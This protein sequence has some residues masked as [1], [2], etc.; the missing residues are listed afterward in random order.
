MR[1]KSKHAGRRGGMRTSA[2]LLCGA[3]LTAVLMA[4]PTAALAQ[5]ANRNWDANGT[6]SGNGGTGTWSTDPVPASQTWSPNTNGISGPYSVWDNSL[7]DNAIFG[8]T[9]GTVTL[10]TP[11]TVHNIT[12]NSHNYVLTGGTLTLGGTT[13]T[14]GGAGNATIASTINGLSGLTKT[15]TGTLTLTG[16][17]TFANSF[18]VT[19]GSLVLSGSNTF[20]G[21]VDVTGAS[22]TLGGANTFTGDIN[23]TTG[24]LTVSHASALGNASNAINLSTNALLNSSVSLAGRT[25]DLVSGEGG[26][27]G[28][29]GSGHFTGAGSLLVYGG[30]TLSDDTNDFTGNVRVFVNDATASFSSIADAGLAS[31]VG[32]GDTIHIQGWSHA[33]FAGERADDDFFSYTGAGPASTDRKWVIEP[34]APNG[35]PSGEGV[36]IGNASSNGAKLTLTG[37][38]EGIGTRLPESMGLWAGTG[39]IDALGVISSNNARTVEFAGTGA[40]RIITLGTQ[41]SFTGAA[42][43]TNVTVKAASIQNSGVVSSLGAGSDIWVAGVLSYTGGATSTD[44]TWSLTGSLLN[45]GTGAMTLEGPVTVTNSTPTLG[46]SYTGGANRITGAI[47]GTGGL[48]MNGPGTWELDADNSFTGAVNVQNGTLRAART[49]A[50]SGT[51]SVRTDGGTLD[52]NGASLALTTIAGNGGT[53]SLGSGASPTPSGA[54]TIT[55]AAA[56]SY[57][58]AFTGSGALTKQGLG[59]LTLTGASSFT[60]PTSVQ[61]GTLKADFSLSGSINDNILSASSAITLSNGSMLHVKGAAGETNNQ[62]IGGLN[63]TSGANTVRAEVLTGGTLNLYLG[64]ISRTGG[65]VNFDLMPDGSG[66]AVLTTSNADG[67][68]GDW[69]MIDNANFA[70]V[71]AGRI[72]AFDNTDYTNKDDAGTW[73]ATEFINDDQNVANTPFFGTIGSSV[74]IAGLR[75]NA[76]AHSTVTVANGQ[77]LGI[78]GAILV[79]PSVAGRFLTITGGRVTGAAGGGTVSVQQ[80]STSVLTI[81]STIVDNGGATGFTKG[82]TGR[83]QLGGLNSYT[84]V[85]TLSQGNLLIGTLANGG[86]ASSI[87]A[88]S[89]DSANLVLQGGALQYVG[90]T[91]AI[92]DRGFTLVNAGLGVPSIE[93]SSGTTVE[94]QGL[95]TS[96]DDQGLTKTGAGRLTLSNGGNDYVGVT[97]IAGTLSVDNL[98]NGGLASGIGASSAASANLVLQNGGELEYTGATGSTDRGFTLSGGSGALDVTQLG[99]ALTIGS[100]GVVGAGALTK[101]G[102]GTLILCGSNSYSGGTTVAAGTLRAC[103]TS[104]FGSWTMTVNSGAT[105]DLA[106]LGNTVRGL[107]GGGTVTLGSGTLTTNGTGSFSGT[108]SGTGGL[109]VLAGTQTMSGCTSAYTGVTRIDSTL[110]VACLRNGGVASDIGAST[111]GPTN[112]LINGTLQY[113]G[114]N[115]VTNRGFQT[116]N[117]TINVSTA[118]TVLGFAGQVAGTSVT[119]SGAGT[120]ILSGNNTYGGATIIAGGTVRA[121]SSTA[122]GTSGIRLDGANT[123]LDLN[124]FNITADYLHEAAAPANRTVNLTNATLTIDSNGG[125]Y[126]GAIIGTGNLVRGAGGTQT[127]SGCASSYSGTTTISG[128]SVLQVHC[129]ADGG[130]NSSIGASGSGAAN[131]VIS[132]GSSLRYL[133]SGGST[134]RQFTLGTG[135]GSLY[136]SGTGAIAFTST[137]PIALT[138]TNAART[139][140]LRGTNTGNNLLAGLIADNGTGR[141]ALTKTDAGTWVLTNPNSTYTGITTISGGVLGVDKLSNGGFASSIGASTASATNLVIGNNSTLRY[142]GAGDTTNRL[143]TLSAGN[144]I[145]ESSGTGAIVFTDTGPVTLQTNNAN[146]VVALGGTNTGNNTLAGSLR[147]AGTGITTLAKNDSGTWVLTG[148]NT[149]TGNTVINDGN[150]VIGNGGNTGNAGAGNVIVDKVTSTLSFNR[151]DAFGFA[152]TLSGL[153]SIAQIGTGTTVLTAAGNSIGAARVDDGTLQVDGTLRTATLAMNGDGTLAVN[154]MV[155]G[156]TAGASSALTGNAG[157]STITVNSGGTLRGN[158]DL[159]GG[160]DTVALAGTL[161]TVGGTLALGAGDDRLV[162]DDPAVLTGGVVGGDGADTLQVN[163]AANRALTVAQVDGF[164]ALHK[165]LGGTLTLTGAHDFSG[166]TTV[167]AGVLAL[168]DG[169]TAGSV[170]SDIVDHGQVHFNSPGTQTYAGTITG[171]GR[172]LKFGGGTLIL[173]GD[174]GYAGRTSVAAG[175]LLINGNQSGATGFTTVS[176]GATLGGSGT[177]GGDVVM[178]AGA[179][180]SP[181]NSPGTLTIAGDLFLDPAAQLDFELGEANVAGGT[182][183]DLVNV[184]G[185]LILDG[186]LNIT[187]S[188]GGAFGRGIY[189]LFNYAGTLT[190]NMLDI[191]GAPAGLTIQTSVANQV[192][193]INTQGLVL[194]YWDGSA[195]P[196]DNGVIDGGA[197]TWQASSGNDNWADE[198]GTPN[199]GYLDSSI[200]VF[201]G[202]AGTVTVDEDLG[203]INVSGF[204]FITSGYVIEGDPINLVE[205]QTVIQVG[206]GT[207]AETGYIATIGAALGGTGQLAK[208]DGGTLVL[209]GTNSYTGGTAVFSGTLRISS[210]G[211]LGAASGGLSLEGGTL[212]TTATMV[213]ARNVAINSGSTVR[214]DPGTTLTLS[215]ALSGAGMLTK[216]GTGTLTLTGDAAHTGGT[217]IAGT[218]RIGDGGATGSIAGHIVNNGTLTFDR[219]G[220]LSYGGAISGAGAVNLTGGAIYEF[221]GAS[222]YTG[223]TRISGAALVVSSDA[224][225]GDVA[226]S[227]TLDGGLLRNTAAFT[228]ARAAILEAGGGT[229]HTDAELTWTGTITGAGLLTKTG[230][231][232]LLLTGTNDYAGGTA[233]DGG[234]LV[235]SSDANLGDAAGAITFDSGRLRNAAAFAT[236]R[237]ATLEAGGG[238]IQ[239]DA[240]LTWSGTITGTGALAKTGAGTLVLTGTNDYAGGTTVGAGTLRIGD[241]GTSGSILGDVVNDAALVFDRSD[242][243]TFGGLVSGTGSLTQAG[244]GTLTLT[245]VNSYLGGT[246]VRTGTLQVSSDAN[247]GDAAGGLTLDSGTLRTSADMASARGVTLVGLASIAPDAGTTLALAGD[248]VGTGS[249]DVAGGG[250]LILSG[251]NSYAGGTSVGGGGTLLIDGDNSAVTAG[252]SVLGATLGGT[253]TIGGD[254]VLGDFATL[255]P[256]SNGVGALTIG[257]DLRSASSSSRFLAQFGEANAPGSPLND[258][259][260]VAGDLTLDGTVDVAVSPGGSFAP[261][262]YRMFDYG[263]ILTDNG[264]TVGL[265]PSGTAFVQTA[266]LQQVNLV[267]TAG[268][269]LDFWDGGAGPKNDG[270]IQGGSGTWRVSGGENNWSDLGGSMNADYADGSFAIFQG[271]GGTVTIDD[272]GG[273][274]SAAGMQFAADGYV[275]AGDMLTLTGTDAFVRVGDGSASDSGI[276]T[277]IGAS[278]TG[279]AGLVKDLAGTLVLT[280]ANSYTGGTAIEGGTLRISADSNLGDAAGGLS[281]DGGTLNTTATLTSNRAVTLAGAGTFLA[282]GPTTLTLGGVVA[283]GGALTK[284]GAGT[285]VLAAAN[286]YA[287]GT[288]IAAGTLQ[289]GAGGTAGSI[290]GDVVNNGAL[291][292]NRSND[293]TFAGAITGG[294]AVDQIGAGTTILTADSS[295][296]GGTTID[297][298][299]LRLGA[300]GT[301]GGITGDVL[302]DGAL[303]FDRSNAVTFAGLISGSGTLEQ[304]GSGTTILTGSNSYAGATTVSGG[305]LL[306]NGDQS[307]AAGHTIVNVG[308]SLGGVGTIGGNVSV[309][310]GATLTPGDAIGA[311]TLT[312][313]GDLGL[314]AGSR[315]AFDFGQSNVVGGPL[316]DLV[317]IGGDLTLGGTIDVAVSPGGSFDVGVYRVMS[318]GGTLTDNGLAIGTM[319]A[320]AIVAVQT[321]IAGQVNLVNSAGATL[322]FWDGA[323]GPKLNGF[324]DG[325]NGLWQNSAGNDNWADSAGAFNGP[326]SD[327]QFAIF[328]AAAGTVTVDNSLGA[329]AAAGMQFASGG[330]RIAG[331]DIVLVGPQSVIRVGDGTAAGSG[332][333]ATIDA[334]LTGDSQLVKTDLGTLVLGGTNSYTGGTLIDL[335]T[336]R[337]ASDASLGAAAGVLGL[338]GATLHTTA[339]FSSGRTVDLI[340]T[341]TFVTDADTSLALAGAL[342]G[343]GNLIKDGAGTL[344]LDGT[345]NHTGTTT[346]RAGSLF[347]NGDLS[348]ATGLTSAASGSM[349]GGTGIIGGDVV[350]ADGGTL[351]PGI[352]AGTLTINGSLSLSAGS[353]LNFEFGEAD[354]VG[355]ALNDL[356]TIGGDLVLDGTINVA[357]PVGG[358]FGPGLYRVFDYG[359]TLTDNGLALGTLPPG[360]VSVQTAI[361]GQVNLVNTAGQTLNFWDGDAGPK[362]NGA[363][364]GGSGIWRVGGGS[365]NWTSASGSLNAD[366]AQGGFAIFAGAPGTVTVDSAGGDVLASGLQFATDGYVLQGDALTL[367]GSETIVQVGDGSAA[368]AGYAATVAS[369]LAGSGG[370][371]K[372][373]AGTLILSGAGSYIGAT[374]VGAGT[375]LVN[376]NY[377]GAVGATTV[378]GG[379]SIGGTGTIG[380]DVALLDGATLTPG[381]GGAGTLTI[382]GDLSLAAGATLAYEFGQAGAAGGGL[383]DLVDVGG[384]LIL[385]G[386]I[387][388]TVS[389]GGAFDIGVYRVFD[390]GG[391][392]TDNG[393]ALGILPAGSN[394]A[395]QTSVA[396]QVNL[397]NAVDSAIAFWD[398]AAGPRN[399]GAIEGGSGTW[400]NRSGNDN[401]ANAQ[402]AVNAAYRDGLFAVFGAAGGTVTIDD[403]LGAVTA[404]GMQFAADGYRLTGDELVLMGPQAMVRVGDGSAAGAG[405]T[406]TI[407]AALS[408]DTQL[409]KTDAGTLVLGGTNSYTGGTAINGGTLQ[410]ASDANLGAAAG[411]V[412]MSGG[413]LATSATLTSARVFAL[414]GA[415]TIAPASGTVFTLSGRITGAGALTT[416]GGTL[417]LTGDSSAYAGSTQVQGTLVVNGSLCGDVNVLAGARL[418]GTGTIC[419]T[420]N[421]GTIATGNSI[422]TLTV[423]GDYTG[424]GGALEVEAELG[425]DASPS[426]RLVVTGNTFGSTAVTVINT[427]GLGAQTVEGIKIVDVG[428]SSAGTFTLNGDYQFEGSPAVVAGAFGYR[429]F[430]GGASTPADGDWYL[431]SALLDGPGEPQAPLYQPGVP[432]YESYAGTLQKLNG[433]ATL[434]ERVGNRRWSGFTQGGAGMWGRAEGRRFRP[435]VAVSTSGT[436]VDTDTWGLQVGLDK[437]LRDSSTGTLIAGVNARHGS[438][439]ARVR[440]RFG[441]GE[442]DTHSYGIGATL[443]WYGSDGLYADAQ[444]QLSWFESDLDSAVLGSLASDSDGS[445][446]AFSFEIGHRLPLGGRLS[447]TPQAQIVYSN[448]RFDT[449]TDPHDAAVSSRDGESLRGRVGLSIDH[450]NSWEQ[451]S[452]GT[453]R[454]HVYG[455]VNLEYEMLG[456]TIVDVSGTPLLR[457]ERRLSSEVG[458][459][460][461]HTWNEGRFTLFSEVSANTAVSDFGNSNG[462]KADAGFRMRF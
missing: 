461:S 404:A 444:A 308:G 235:V 380:G 163:N 290:G 121:G 332:F 382:A 201:Q 156:A 312:I 296:T 401:W 34:G 283:G 279:S 105:L 313:N 24:T 51:T 319:P 288:T 42:L 133:G 394:V 395:V 458:L 317:S 316:N 222:S 180:L 278:L 438:A 257:G 413:T 99:T 168:G 325:G 367:T 392:L 260:D 48:T 383:N 280:G 285:L 412:T 236:S 33:A 400:Q 75:Y 369:E 62:T 131:L 65:T 172:V 427:G 365:A 261:G 98:A 389:A 349:L 384:N 209:T 454:N 210:D 448:V 178:A 21:D 137:A 20:S 118:G 387:D 213:S 453:V 402:G 188:I 18:D 84:G 115:V 352:S 294:G 435:T 100:S 61:A 28:Q 443:T 342:T 53:I 289:I 403:S 184:G 255:A 439:D 190:D 2:R 44:R 214:T 314:T 326:F 35:G 179:T 328:S 245:G 345:S 241:G 272:A 428:G 282:D 292:F 108:V 336:L 341:G 74:Q 110:S 390:Y 230:T 434:Q 146:Y 52:L 185:D 206:D 228:T 424:T 132:G 370:L 231:G 338:D 303:V 330:Y 58:G 175:T 301:T 425:G 239:T 456:S 388:V 197:G 67:K 353:V 293:L 321:T 379:A 68:L 357:V 411:A 127:L 47:T 15:G 204:Q 360:H 85:T 91:D 393:L 31:A 104:A 76:N 186:T 251:T 229:I 277:T 422:G 177:I 50:L 161:D 164:E 55:N 408:G 155:E 159:G 87:G 266:I 315:L 364:D 208:A 182:Y 414:T 276:T 187:E 244:A 5:D 419:T 407:D 333:V 111:S 77:T 270:L 405:F 1:L 114:G 354:A 265:L 258:V 329:V 144:T 10:G 286:G 459:G 385:D 11:I 426:D 128:A 138:G 30:V 436:D 233:I 304:A 247:L 90:A 268:L 158:G 371:A 437:A 4:L 356:V 378:A 80:N 27:Q 198:L 307:A 300:G 195:G 418:G 225:L 259:V 136:A 49:T 217:V 86:S 25:I 274:V 173:T 183:N 117:G 56:Q 119:K 8:S 116:T 397:V 212:H 16:N 237:A 372:T 148:D 335:G 327:G 358:T 36:F 273:A 207:P 331:Q 242:D 291:A 94:F 122:F 165:T 103:S 220:A 433:L 82:G 243:V 176:A 43:I 102:A 112:L 226:S 440:S 348:L 462:F 295:Y 455:I 399:N 152:G 347:I 60:G 101:N 3:S 140:T 377:A 375:L 355:G 415:G 281:L 287:G 193:L 22:L 305:T 376:G 143:F 70:K 227:L 373:G 83:V 218:M 362:N 366:Y 63:I 78:D 153:G 297:V 109:T 311:G 374:S 129:L 423:A 40:S 246:T 162:L 96:T 350:V 386:T 409:V 26:I 142:T 71:V 441:N 126:S 12:F 344:A 337:I 120:L 310:D 38:I 203:A 154:G 37:D 269:T 196:K 66:N 449:F 199:G 97:T 41:N 323:A 73:S 46:G 157:A 416:A 219:T 446:E 7:L 267:N 45:D 391:A 318:Y 147:N 57:S 351:A 113:T 256:G 447:V 451:P 361:A 106:N 93:V 343:A 79:T 396:G 249:L 194:R 191:A 262:V 95:V 363:V 32:A 216:T 59:V 211:N 420:V 432:L 445:G 309:N 124:G 250:T 134:N 13:P 171:T 275:I 130:S 88:S 381:A 166:G 263:G 202:A 89:A 19:G 298:G 340:G 284:D 6:N 346:V 421:A 150:L 17:N 431:R 253:G 302:N 252:T 169:V 123:T 125:V 410:I 149:F 232:S 238:T 215:G 151:N 254:V 170:T 221:T 264:M 9:A 240:D 334:A 54:V 205:P 145:I 417:V 23:V 359:G 139:L 234:T 189:R 460:L 200:P 29:A 271:T 398:G 430:Q 81:G 339:S 72:V 64:A 452:G 368:S 192:N 174:N 69:A 406:A 442:I 306:I 160:G 429:L 181:G 320:G 457:R 223:G 39:D 107:N 322:A 141:T 224:N 299:T 248:I 167:E 324:V 14:I 135:G 450:E 92:T